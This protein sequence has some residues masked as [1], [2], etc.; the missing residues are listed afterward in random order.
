[1]YHKIIQE[2]VLLKISSVAWID[3]HFKAWHYTVNI[4]RN[5]RWIA[6]AESIP[7]LYI[8][9]GSFPQAR[10]CTLFVGSNDSC[11]NKSAICLPLCLCCFIPVSNKLIEETKRRLV[12]NQFSYKISIYVFDLF[13][14]HFMWTNSFSS[15]YDVAIFFLSFLSK[16]LQRYIVVAFI[17]LLM[18]KRIYSVIAEPFL[19]MRASLSEGIT[20]EK[21]ST[22]NDII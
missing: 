20:I 12:Y 3:G 6:Y 15:C 19:M 9:T 4:N 14:F 18:Y 21:G 16:Q 22:I 17:S 13:S 11:T 8:L 1:M 7:I 2:N 10:T 5:R